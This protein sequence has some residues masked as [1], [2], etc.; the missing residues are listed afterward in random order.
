[1]SKVSE[2]I[3][4]LRKSKGLTQAELSQ[5]TRLSISAIKSYETGLREPNFKAIVAL[6]SFFGVTGKDLLGGTSSIPKQ[7]KAVPAEEC[8]NK[9][10]EQLLEIF[11]QLPK[12]DQLILIGKAAELYLRYQK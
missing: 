10:R 7:V 9:E 2:T 3:Q 12:E 4:K 1:M 6:E 8:Q 5:R 11:D